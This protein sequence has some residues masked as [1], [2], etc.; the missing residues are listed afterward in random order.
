MS[1]KNPLPESP[2]WVSIREVAAYC[3]V[4]ESTV[5]RGYKNRTWPYTYLRRLPLG[6]RVVFTRTS[7]SAMRRAM[8]KAVEAVPE[9]V[10]SIEEG[11]R[12]SA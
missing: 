2:D 10:V 5:S 3:T 1:A 4:D 6:A 7:F 12:R 9:E 8:L 11:R